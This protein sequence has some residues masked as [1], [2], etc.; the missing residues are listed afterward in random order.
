MGRGKASFLAIISAILYNYLYVHPHGF[1][2]VLGG[3]WVE[4]SN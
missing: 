4:L 1:L 3:G 2:A